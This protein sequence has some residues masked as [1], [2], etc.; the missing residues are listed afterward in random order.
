MMMMM[1]M[2]MMILPS[3]LS[4]WCVCVQDESLERLLRESE[5][6]ERTYGHYFDV[7]IINNDIDDTIRVLQKSVDDVCTLPQWV[8]ISWVY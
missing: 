5:A 2:M 4:T 7:K 8:P 1:M 6:L 3:S